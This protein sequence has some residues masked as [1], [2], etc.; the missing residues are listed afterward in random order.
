MKRV[1][2]VL[3]MTASYLLGQSDLSAIVL[4]DN[5]PLSYIPCFNR[6]ATCDS[7]LPMNHFVPV[8]A[9]PSLFL[10]VDGTLIEFS[11]RPSQTRAPRE[12]LGLLKTLE[13]KLQGALALIS[14]RSIADL[15]NIFHPLQLRAAGVHGGE[16]REQAGTPAPSSPTDPNLEGL[17]RALLPILTKFPGVHVE[18]KRIAFAVHYRAQPEARAVLLREVASLTADLGPGYQLLDGNLAIEVKPRHF[19]KAHAIEGFLAQP[20]FAN[21]TPVFLGDDITDLDGF[22]VIERHGGMS[23]AVGTRVDAQWRLPDP[24]ATRRWL[25]EL[26]VMGTR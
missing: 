6:A 4:P 9:Q 10:D 23:V 21:R 8:P 26:A 12:L 25:A 24:A 18:N 3:N 20:E 14:G 5:A 11:A 22:E 1:N 15:D 13:D 17:H 19:T 16:R 7:V 2:T